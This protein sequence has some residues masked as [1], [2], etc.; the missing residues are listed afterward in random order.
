LIVLAAAGL[1]YLVLRA[2][3]GDL[4][5]RDWT[6]I[7]AARVALG[8]V[9]V[10]GISALL[11]N[12]STLAIFGLY[13]EMIG[14]IFFLA[15]VGSWGVGTGLTE[16]DRYILEL[17]LVAGAVV[18]SVI[19]LLQQ[20]VGLGAI[21]LADY[22]NQPTGMLG[23]P[24]FLGALL[25]G[26]LVLLGAR[27][28]NAPRIWITFVL[29]IGLGLGADGERLP[30]LLA[31][32]VAVWHVWRGFRQRDRSTEGE[33]VWRRSL[34]FG[35]FTVGGI[36]VGSILAKV[37]GGLGAIGRATSSTAGET[38][39]QRF[40]VWKAAVHALPNHLILGAGPDQF[41]AATARYFPFSFAQSNGEVSF[42]DAH[43]LAL[44]LLVTVG[45]VGTA[46]F[47]GWLV[48][49]LLH[50][51][52]PLL[53]FG[54]VL[55]A[56]ELFEPLNLVI[57]PLAFLAFG[58]AALRHDQVERDPSQKA[59]GDLPSP[60]R[61]PRW[62]LV[63]SITMALLALIPAVVLLVGDAAYER[64]L[65]L[66]AAK[67]PAT[68]GSA[69]LANSILAPW[70]EPAN[71]LSEIYFD[72]YLAGNLTQFSTARDWEEV[73]IDRNPTDPA[74]YQF[75]AEMDTAQGDLVAVQKNA[76]LALTYA[77]WWSAPMN[78]LGLVA[79]SQ[80]QTKTA[81]M[82]FD[83]SLVNDR[84]Q[85]GLEGVL[86]KLKR[87]CRAQPLTAQRDNLVFNCPR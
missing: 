69:K 76:R 28:V 57:T 44:E 75:M 20:F 56:V 21:G 52:G 39:G 38:F 34:S 66:E 29:F 80:G 83:R 3:G 82:W 43:N 17:A 46:F 13:V 51:Q 23:N 1:P 14:W 19:A 60:D 22:G 79:A 32:I 74:L 68:L 50:R 33:I 86:Q 41:Q 30:V 70:P 84:E 49:S 77:P 59:R 36:V 61:V 16:D 2:L 71:L 55:L 18:N 6:E 87:G 27:Y 10:T 54:I 48:L 37:R 72:S 9:V 58:A 35:G 4:A 7:W 78:D 42:T 24:V 25:A 73:A 8:F 11:S 81:E 67:Q 15:V 63:A 64:G 5:N 31:V 85:P 65:S 53:G 47:V 26:S 62:V 40:G 45:I 12:S